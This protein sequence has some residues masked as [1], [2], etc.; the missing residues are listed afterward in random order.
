MTADLPMGKI[1]QLFSNLTE[2]NISESFLHTT[3]S[4]LAIYIFVLWKL[5][6]KHSKLFTMQNSGKLE[7]HVINYKFIRNAIFWIRI[8]GRHI[9]FDFKMTKID[10]WVKLR[11][12]EADFCLGQ[13]MLLLDVIKKDK[14]NSG[15]SCF[16]FA[17]TF[18]TESYTWLNKL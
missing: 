15:N 7:G 2:P 1:H 13:S 17:N 8:G 14:I 6:H 4:H 10:R 12:L 5:L 16:V 3:D 9:Q 18:A 11:Q